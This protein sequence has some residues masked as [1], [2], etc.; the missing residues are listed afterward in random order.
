MNSTR[1]AYTDADFFRMPAKPTPEEIDAILADPA[2]RAAMSRQEQQ[3]WADEAMPKVRALMAAGWQ[4]EVVH[5]CCAE[6]WQWAWRRPP[7]RKGSLGMRFAGT[8]QAYNAL[9]RERGEK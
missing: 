8:N 7:R 4:F 2:K 9:M 6:P 1:P 5:E 3:K